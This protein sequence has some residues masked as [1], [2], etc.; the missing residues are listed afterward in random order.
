VPTGV[1]QACACCAAT[2]CWALRHAAYLE[3]RS[4]IR[5][6][7]DEDERSVRI[8]ELLLRSFSSEA[9]RYRARLLEDD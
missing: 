2:L 4:R 7:L 6:S 5:G 3:A 9:E 8:R 1:N